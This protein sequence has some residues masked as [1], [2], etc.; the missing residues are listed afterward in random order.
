MS[1]DTNDLPPDDLPPEVD[2]LIFQWEEEERAERSPAD[3]WEEDHIELVGD[4]KA[5]NLTNALDGLVSAGCSRRK[6]LESLR[7]IESFVV[8]YSLIPA[9]KLRNFVGRF[10]TLA[11]QVEALEKSQDFYYVPEAHRVIDGLRDLAKVWAFAFKNE[12]KERDKLVK[13]LTQYVDHNV[14][15]RG[16][17]GKGGADKAVALLVA[18]MT[19]TKRTHD[20]IRVARSRMKPKGQ[21][22][23]DKKSRPARRLRGSRLTGRRKWVSLKTADAELARKQL[24]TRGGDD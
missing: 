3:W 1:K 21:I 9:R 4:S 24:L 7:D 17:L 8:G 18:E 11:S 19:H 6:I 20:A 2:H 23:R 12:K 15:E 10:R 16:Q 13:N 5:R 22:V 14:R